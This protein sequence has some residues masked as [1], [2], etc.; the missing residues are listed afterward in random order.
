MSEDYNCQDP[1]FR[2]APKVDNKRIIVY[3][4]DIENNFSV[5]K[6]WRTNDGRVLPNSG[7]R[8]ELINNPFDYG[9]LILLTSHFDPAIAGKGFGGFGMRAPITPAIAITNQTYIEFDLY[10]PASAA[11][12]YM[13]FEIWSTSSGGEGSQ[14]S[15][16]V[17]GA[18]KTQVYIRPAYLDILS[19]Q[20]QNWMEFYKGERWF[21]K[22]FCRI[23]P[24][25]SGTW[26]YINFD[27]HTETGAIVDG[28]QLMIGNIRITQVD[29]NEG[30]IPDVVNTKNYREVAP[31]KSKYNKNAGYFL[32]GTTAHEPA[33]DSI[34]DYHFELI[35][36]ENNLMPAVHLKPP[37]WLV[38]QFL[39]FPFRYDE[40]PEWNL[41][42]DFYLKIL[43]TGNPGELKIHGQNLVWNI[44]SPPWMRQIIPENISSMHWNPDGLFYTGGVNASGPYQKTDRETAKRICFN[45]ILHKMR[46]FMTTDERYG[47]CRE[48]GMIP[49]HS[50]GVIN[51]EMQKSRHSM[52]N[53][54]DPNEWKSALLNTSWLMAM[55]DADYDDIRQHYMYLIF[56]YA[57]IAVPNAQMAAKFKSGYNDPA[58]V[59][60]YMKMDNHDNNGCI[61]DFV[62]E[63]SPI[64][65][66]N[67]NE[68]ELFSKAKIIYN[69]TKELNEAWKSDPLYDGRN[70]I[71]CIGI[72]G[73]DIVSSDI[74]SQSQAAVALFASLVDDGLLDC[75]CYSE[76]D[77]KQQSNAPGGEALAPAVL[78]EK[79]ADSIGYQY[80]L[81]FKMFDKY[82]K[83]IDHITI[84]SQYGSS[85][86]NSYVLFDHEKKASQAYYG[87]MDPD[88]FIQGHSYLDDFFYGEY[89]KIKSVNK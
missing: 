30:T 6:S 52:I 9:S 4:F 2:E 20:K 34:M 15:A 10:Y 11:G 83:Y 57:H 16:G 44:A 56:K 68:L 47:S 24:V 13:R 69:M 84:W 51:D 31:V 36:H 67:D 27:L 78:N 29:P 86:Q 12:K 8:F 77:L 75:I 33:G 22:S 81:L 41:P 59:P 21:K 28:D 35:T 62:Y 14:S 73:H 64:L 63:K 26:E 85:L 5:W 65:I 42:T 89:D 71:E 7:S 82:K 38:D 80:A 1:Y 66:V 40:G 72:H 58:I 45:H 19:N 87:V 60:G 74:V 79:Q 43:N 18:D 53:I 54:N 50:F 32:M 46:H 39:K 48:R 55:T 76:V 23:I 88:R 37:K 25:S 70:L 49:F 61:D 3:K 17:P